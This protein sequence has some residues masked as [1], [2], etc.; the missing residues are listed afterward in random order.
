MKCQRCGSERIVEITAK[1]PDG[2][3]IRIGQ[4]DT[5]SEAITNLC[6]TEYVEP[7]VCLECGQCQGTW[8]VAYLLPL[9]N[10]KPAREEKQY[11]TVRQWLDAMMKHKC[12]QGKSLLP[13]DDVRGLVGYSCQGCGKWFA[14]RVCVFRQTI[15]GLGPGSK[16]IQELLRYRDGRSMLVGLLNKEV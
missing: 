9:Y 6:G 14:I 8:P 11:A 16:E 13:A 15:G 10:Q 7:K 1:C 5:K 4:H 2:F 12:K 3:D